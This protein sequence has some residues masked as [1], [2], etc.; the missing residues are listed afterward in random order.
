MGCQPIGGYENRLVRFL[1]TI[2]SKTMA[3]SWAY[4]LR[5]KGQ[6]AHARNR[7]QDSR[8][9]LVLHGLRDRQNYG[10]GFKPLGYPGFGYWLLPRTSL[11]CCLFLSEKGNL[12]VLFAQVSIL[13][14]WFPLGGVNWWVWWDAGGGEAIRVLPFLVYIMSS[15][16]RTPWGSHHIILFLTFF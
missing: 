7:T 11:V 12:G 16:I 8:V 13:A 3:R 2:S 15:R 1:Q 5:V 14:A 4:V 9:S 6:L 10:P